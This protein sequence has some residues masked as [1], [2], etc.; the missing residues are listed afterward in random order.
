VN[1]RVNMT[2]VR[3]LVIADEWRTMAGVFGLIVLV[4][5]DRIIN[6]QGMSVYNYFYMNVHIRKSGK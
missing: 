3:A 1:E 2:N 4:S 6:E 5:I